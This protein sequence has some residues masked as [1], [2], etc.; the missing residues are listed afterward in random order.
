MFS[1]KVNKHCVLNEVA[2]DKVILMV[3]TQESGITLLVLILP[4]EFKQHVVRQSVPS[5]TKINYTVTIDTRFMEDSKNIY[6]ASYFFSQILL[7]T[8]KKRKELN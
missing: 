4:A 3:A 5:E 6:I 2:Y 8:N 1:K 7:Q